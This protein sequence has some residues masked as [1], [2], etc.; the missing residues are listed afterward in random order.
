MRRKTRLYV[1]ATEDSVSFVF[2]SG[3]TSER[4][5]LFGEPHDRSVNPLD[6][7]AQNLH[8]VLQTGR[9]RAPLEEGLNDK[10]LFFDRATHHFLYLVSQAHRA[11][12]GRVGR[13]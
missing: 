7:R 6:V 13:L 1:E 10:P 12:H 4:I 5:Y 8:P 2:R 3:S 11:L 9:D